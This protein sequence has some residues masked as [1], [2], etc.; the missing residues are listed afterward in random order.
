VPFARLLALLLSVATL[1]LAASGC[2]GGGNESSASGTKPETWAASVCGA[3][4]TWAN[5]LKTGSQSLSSDLQSSGDLKG[6]KEKLVTFLQ[7]ARTS[8]QTMVADVEAA[9][10]PAVKDGEAIQND[11]E[12]GL[13]AARDSFDHAVTTAKDLKATNPT[14]FMAGVTNLGQQIQT[15]LQKTA[16]HFKNIETKYDAGDLDEAMSNEPACKPFASSG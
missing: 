4:E 15:E 10:P 9:G 1:A 12:A 11:L 6:V 3:L 16:E 13:S 7:N 5:D 14:A 2:G 8:T